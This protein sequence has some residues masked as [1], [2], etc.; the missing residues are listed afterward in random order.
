MRRRPRRE[1]IDTQF[2]SLFCFASCLPSTCFKGI[3]QKLTIPRNA[4]IRVHKDRPGPCEADVQMLLIIREDNGVTRGV[5]YKAEVCQAKRG[6]NAATQGAHRRI[7]VR[8]M[9]GMPFA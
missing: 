9:Q 5:V 6:D 4:G 3:A 8:S 1:G 2:S 7:L